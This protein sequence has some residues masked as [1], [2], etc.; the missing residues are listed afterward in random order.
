MLKPI[1]VLIL[2]LFILSFS[3]MA[4]NNYNE[5]SL[6]E[7]M[8]KKQQGDKNMLIVD[9]RT[10]GEYGDTSRSMQ[11][12][13]GHIK[14][15]INITLQDLQQNPDAVKQLDAFRDKDIYLICSHSYRSRAASNILLKNGFSHVNNV[16]GGMTEWYRRYD[17]L[18]PYDTEFL[19]KGISY[20]NISPAQLLNEL[21]SGRNVL[22]LGI[23]N[24]PRFWYDSFNLK[25]YRYYPQFKKTVYFNY[26][27]SLKILEEAQKEK[28]RPIVLFNMLNSGAAE[29]A[30]WLTT[31]SIRDIS[32]LVGGENLLYEYVQNKQAAEK[33]SNFFTMQSGI[34]FISPPVYC[35]AI[36][37]NKNIQMVDV[38]H[39]SLFNKI[40]EGTKHDFK[41]L[42]DAVNFFEGRGTALFEQE[43]PD[44]KKEYVL[45]SDNGIDGLEFADALVKKGYKI[46]WLIGGLDRWEWYMNNVEDFGCNDFLIQ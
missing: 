45:V 38:R 6:P 21:N 23:R 9:V 10:K 42:K 16:R 29:L 18:S 19:K 3:S 22:L 11:S 41:H 25:L 24:T 15:A 20:K 1:P 30:E 7:L 12:N 28:G 8:K 43:F 5:I 13:I 17:E 36:T 35:A 46:Y 2:C 39:D 4:Q 32:Y 33:T 44:R 27:D 14:G 26:A 37:K 34:R 31:K 40:N